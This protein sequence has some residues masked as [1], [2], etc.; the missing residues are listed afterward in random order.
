[1]STDPATA[2]PGRAF[3]R[4]GW[5]LVVV[6]LVSCGLLL[7]L[8]AWLNAR[9]PW[10]FRGILLVSVLFGMGRAVRKLVRG[11]RRKSRL[12][13]GT[14]ALSLVVGLLVLGFAVVRPTLRDRARD[15]AFAVLRDD[16]QNSTE[17]LTALAADMPE[18]GPIDLPRYQD[19]AGWLFAEAQRAAERVARAK[20]EFDRFTPGQRDELLAE[21]ERATAALGRAREKFAGLVPTKSP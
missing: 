1:M 9:Y 15:A 8:F 14:A 10:V 4:A 3:R 21:G 12:D 2:D 5:V 17:A 13:V 7:W 20:A 6:L 11:R 19:L 16:L 18:A